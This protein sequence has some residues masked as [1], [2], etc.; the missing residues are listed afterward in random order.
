MNNRVD[1]NLAHPILGLSILLTKMPLL[2]C[3]P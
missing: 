3:R 1:A 2:V